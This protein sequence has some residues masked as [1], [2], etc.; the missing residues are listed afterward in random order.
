MEPKDSNQKKLQCNSL[1]LVKT[2]S[3]ISIG[4]IFNDRTGTYLNELTLFLVHFNAIPNC[5]T[6]IEIDCR[7][8]KNWFVE[9]YKTAV[10]DL[11]YNKIYFEGIKNAEFDDVFY[12]LYGDLIVNFDTNSSIARFLFRKTE[13][14]Q[15]ETIIAGIKKFKKKTEK[16]LP[17][18]S[19]LIN[20]NHGISTKSFQITRP[21]LSLDDN[22][23]DDFKPIHQTVIKRLSTK[24]DKGLVLLHGKPGTG[25]TS[26]IRYLITMLK[27]DVIFLPLNMASS[28][29]DPNLISILIDNPNCIFVIED[30][31]HIIVDRERDGHSPVAALLNISDGLL[32][33]CLNIQI[34]CSFNTDI[35]KVGNALV[36]K[37]R[38]IAKYEFKELETE[39]A[40][41]L[42]D[43]LS[44]NTKIYKPMIL[45]EIYN[46][47]QISFEQSKQKNAIGFMANSN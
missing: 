36:R 29:T 27:K 7:R 5:I 30:A 2:P 26:Y 34:I 12:I 13:I 37:G 15:I 33:D 44:F 38:L 19:L 20:G 11:H 1:E 40:Q 17:E 23:N 10:T 6:E 21:Q 46:Q 22:Y 45:T 41:R 8:A 24:N 4:G 42:S 32:S 18:I 43:K 31:E 25:K 28:I 35:S 47:N 9:N 3:K 14:V 16:R 39:K